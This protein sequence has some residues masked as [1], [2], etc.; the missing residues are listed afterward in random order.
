M[1]R[2]LRAVIRRERVT[3]IVDLGRGEFEV[4]GRLLSPELSYI[5]CDIAGSGKWVSPM[6]GHYVTSVSLTFHV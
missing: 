3:C 2:S 6:L 5:G 4:G 1:F